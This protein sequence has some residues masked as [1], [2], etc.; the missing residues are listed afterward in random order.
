MSKNC[1]KGKIVSLIGWKHD[2]ISKGEP[3]Y[4]ITQKQ[5]MKASSTGGR[6][7]FSQA[8]SQFKNGKYDFCTFQDMTSFVSSILFVFKQ[9]R[10][11]IDFNDTTHTC[12]RETRCTAKV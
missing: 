4:P 7:L 5:S 11:K 10:V 1:F 8:D 9:S 6:G 2:S 3:F 12:K